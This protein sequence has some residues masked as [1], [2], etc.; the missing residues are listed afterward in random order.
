MKRYYFH[1]H[2]CGRSVRDDEGAMLPDVD[3]AR[4]RAMVE[5]RSIMCAEVS[6]GRL[7]LNCNIEVLD[8]AGRLAVNVPF[9]E[10]VALSGI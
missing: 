5:A 4:E 2:E 1:L 9:K 8:E 10:A 7:C 6:E 3:A